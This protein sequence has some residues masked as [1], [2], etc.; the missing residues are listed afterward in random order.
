MIIEN[1]TNNIDYYYGDLCVAQ[2]G[3]MRNIISILNGL[4][5]KSMKIKLLRDH[6]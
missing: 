3:K 2:F 1:T 5:M 6:S 4:P